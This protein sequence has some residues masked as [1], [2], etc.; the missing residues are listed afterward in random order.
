MGLA[1][2][3]AHT[4][5]DRQPSGTVL[6]LV[7]TTRSSVSACRI[8]PRAAVRRADRRWLPRHRPHPDAFVRDRRVRAGQ[9]RPGC[10]VRHRAIRGARHLDH[11]VPRRPSRATAAVAVHRRVELCAHLPRGTLPQSGLARR[12]PAC[13]PRPLNCA[14][15]PHCDHGGGGNAR[16]QPGVGCVCAHHERRTR[17]RYGGV[18]SASRRP[19]RPRL[20]S[21]L[22]ALVPR[23]R[24]HRVGMAAPAGNPTFCRACQRADR[25][26]RHR[27]R[28]TT[29]PFWPSRREPAAACPVR[30]P[31]ER[32]SQRIP[33]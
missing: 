19:L 4:A 5:S 25:P 6:V 11:V 13:C 18:G 8:D 15:H 9:H 14:R 27:P 12:H 21:N 1:L 16:S 33:A 29:D 32:I 3:L 28:A 7:G 2:R 23:H 26:E 31:G 22:P 17:F 20:A 10:R 24:R 30:R